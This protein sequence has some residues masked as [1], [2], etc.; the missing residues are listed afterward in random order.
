[1]IYVFA[2]T[3]D[4]GMRL[5]EDMQLDRG[6]YNLV[7][8]RSKSIEGLRLDPKKDAVYVQPGVSDEF[9]AQIKRNADKSR[10]PLTGWWNWVRDVQP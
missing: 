5:V 1:V 6:E 7:S 3:R 10:F 2:K 8:E 4:E 9:M